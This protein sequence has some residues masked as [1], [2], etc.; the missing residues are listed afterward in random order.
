MRLIAQFLCWFKLAGPGAL[1]GFG[2]RSQGK[3]PIR[4]KAPYKKE[5]RKMRY[6]VAPEGWLDESGQMKAIFT[7]PVSL[8]RLQ[9]C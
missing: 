8:P 3:V 2:Q 5:I 9:R 6:F 1:P 4:S 7:S